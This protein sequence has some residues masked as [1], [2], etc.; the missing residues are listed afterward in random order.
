MGKVINTPTKPALPLDYKV[1]RSKTKTKTKKTEISDTSTNPPIIIKPLNNN[2]NVT[3]ETSAEK[4]NTNTELSSEQQ[5]VPGC[6]YSVVQ[7]VTGPV[8]VPLT[9]VPNATTEVVTNAEIPNNDKKVM[10]AL[11]TIDR[12]ASK[13]IGAELLGQHCTCCQIIKSI[14]KEKQT[15]ITDY[16]SN[17]KNV[18]KACPCRRKSFPIVTNKFRLFLEN[19]KNKCYNVWGELHNK[20]TSLESKLT[21]KTAEVS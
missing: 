21:D 5:P 20:I 18:E 14:C 2:E 8:L 4:T 6:L 11:P 19:H 13:Q 12:E 10:D 16:F 1:R 7:T 17:N 15:V 3:T 9:I